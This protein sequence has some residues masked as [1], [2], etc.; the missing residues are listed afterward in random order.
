LGAAAEKGGSPEHRQNG[1]AVRS[2]D[3]SREWGLR[4]L[5]VPGCCVRSFRGKDVRG[6]TNSGVFCEP[7][8][9]FW[10][11]SGC[12]QQ[13]QHWWRADSLL[14]VSLIQPLPLRRVGSAWPGRPCHIFTDGIES[15]MF[16][17]LLCTIRIDIFT[18][19][20]PSER[21]F[22]EIAA[23]FWVKQCQ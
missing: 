8:D 21:H 4:S 10:T 22:F 11:F 23:I 6:T 20:F 13:T 14:A 12:G 16:E 1:K 5:L 18:H 19:F 9:S 7:N 2:G 15:R 17:L 3:Q